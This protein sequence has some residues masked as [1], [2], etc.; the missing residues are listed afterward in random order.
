M[1][2]TF[3]RPSGSRPERPQADRLRINEPST[4]P[5]FYMAH[6]NRW[7]IIGGEVLPILGKLRLIPGVSGV[8]HTGDYMVARA[9]KERRGWTVLNWDVV[10]CEAFGET[11]SDY[12]L[13]WDGAQGKIYTE[14]FTRPIQMGPTGVPSWESDQI[15]YKKFLKALVS[16][17]AVGEPHPAL[18]QSMEHEILGRINRAEPRAP[19]IPMVAR[20]LEQHRA[21]LTIV[22]NLMAGEEPAPSP[23]PTSKKRASK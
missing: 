16:S 19:S 22:Q 14:V 5:F 17:G 9:A 4:P 21:Q 15:G 11:Y 13:Y 8:E 20:Q 3:S 23:R 12:L 10:Q 2:H 1:A 7:G 6:P 18:L